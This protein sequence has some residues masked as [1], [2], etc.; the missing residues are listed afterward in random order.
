MTHEA[1]S[2]VALAVIF[3]GA[4]LGM[5]LRARLPESHLG[6][7]TKD[8]V[9]LGA[10]LIGTLAAL[11]VGLMIASA[12]TS[13][14]A[15]SGYVSRMSADLVQLDR[16]LSEYGPETG[17]ARDMLRRAVAQLIDRIWG[18]GDLGL[19]GTAPFG[20]SGVGQAAIQKI[21]EL[22]PKNDLQRFLQARAV[23]AAGDLQHARFLLAAQPGNPIPPPFLLML[24]A[25]HAIIFA[26]FSLFAPWNATL[27]VVLFLLAA[28]ASGAIFLIL[29]LSRPF[30]GVMNISS[31]PLRNALGES[32]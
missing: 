24:I 2:L 7:D 25:W 22:A 18:Q 23:S 9:R 6:A 27:V 28:S 13:Y 31:A 32:H 15:Q 17:E 21:Q 19:A 1:F 8:V 3:G 29:D 30:V 12:K 4:L 5:F 11:V 20:E 16:I 14:D 26:S 10:G